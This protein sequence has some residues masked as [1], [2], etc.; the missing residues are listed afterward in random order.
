MKALRINTLLLAALLLCPAGAA[1]AERKRESIEWIYTVCHNPGATDLPRVLLIGDSITNMYQEYVSK[2]LSGT[3]YVST[4]TTSKCITDRSFLGELRLMLESGTYALIQF[5]NGLHSW[6]SDLKERERALSEVIKLLREQG[7][8]A[9][10]IWASTTPTESPDNNRLVKEF[11]DIAA[12]VM[13]KNEIPINDLF[14]LMDPLDRKQYW[15]DNCHHSEEGRKIAAKQVVAVIREKLGINES[16][17]VPEAVAAGDQRPEKMDWSK[18]FWYDADKSGLPRVLVIGD[19]I[20]DDYQ[21]FVNS[22][23]AGKVFLSTYSTSR[24]FADPWYVRELEY[25]LDEYTYD[26]ILFNNGLHCNEANPIWNT[27][28]SDIPGWE[29]GLRSVIKL[30]AAKG[31]G[32][33]TIWAASDPWNDTNRPAGV[34]ALQEA[35][36]RV[37]KENSIP[38]RDLYSALKTGPQYDE[39]LTALVASTICGALGID[40]KS[41]E[42]TTG[43]AGSLLGPTGSVGNA[44]ETNSGQ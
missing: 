19:S 9:K 36:A 40:G 33:K 15:T 4:Y 26:V 17:P 23:L 20:Y 38:Q 42:S 39:E 35:A 6:G 29:T 18:V 28:Q 10:I 5:N 12:A 34:K 27:V 32:A 31:N 24:S 13:E 41:G 22:A 37:M 3:A 1:H 14:G 25:L 11:N 30:I 16:K 8:G 43:A 21:R 2:E 44:N 7:K